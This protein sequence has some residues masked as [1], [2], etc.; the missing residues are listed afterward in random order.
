MIL[1]TQQQ[2][3][4]HHVS[5]DSAWLHENAR[6]R[7]RTEKEKIEFI[8][9]CILESSAG[10]T[11]TTNTLSFSNPSSNVETFSLAIQNGCFKQ[12][13]Q[14][15]R[16]CTHLCPELLNDHHHLL[17]PSGTTGPNYHNKGKGKA[18]V[19]AWVVL[20]TSVYPLLVAAKFFFY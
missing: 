19:N 4:P 5:V 18:I 16:L 6:S 20:T 9:G 10:Q 3:L 2:T 7:M 11:R 14:S 12:S 15:P 8:C 1:D 13:D 17:P